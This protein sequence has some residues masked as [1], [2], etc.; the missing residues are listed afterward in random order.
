MTIPIVFLG[1]GLL[2]NVCII[3]FCEELIRLHIKLYFKDFTTFEWINYL[4]R[5]KELKKMLMKK[6]ITT[7]E[8]IELKQ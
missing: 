7:D 2:I 5:I 3:V 1:I 8:F 6:E 4:K